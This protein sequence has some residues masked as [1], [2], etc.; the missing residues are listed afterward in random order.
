VGD[1]GK[2]WGPSLNKGQDICIASSQYIPYMGVF[3]TRLPH[4]LVTCPP[5]DCQVRGAGAP[6]RTD[7]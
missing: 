7:L 5:C 3:C 2:V 4:S 6:A 1:Q